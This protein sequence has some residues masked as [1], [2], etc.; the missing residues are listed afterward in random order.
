MSY[1]LSKAVWLAAQPLSL[2]F[3]AIAIALLCGLLRWRKGQTAFGLIATLIL[4]LAL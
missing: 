1:F 3:L 4:F 2:A